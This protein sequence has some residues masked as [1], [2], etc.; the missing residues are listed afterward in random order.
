MSVEVTEVGWLDRIKQSLVGF[1]V[2]PI[3]ILAAFPTIFLNE[4]CAVNEYKSI[5]EVRAN[6]V[7]VPVDKVDKANDNKLVYTTGEAVTKDVLEDPRFGVA[8]TAVRLERNVEM[9]Q[10][11]ERSS[12]KTE[13]QV[14]GKQKKTTTY[15]YDETWSSSA[16]DSSGFND[17]KYRGVNPSMKYKGDSFSATNVSL[18]AFKLSEELIQQMHGDD[19][20]EIPKDI[21]AKLPKPDQKQAT[22]ANG[23]I[24]IAAGGGSPSSPAVGDLRISFSQAKAGPVSVIGQQTGSTFQA[25]QT[26]VGSPKLLLSRG[27]VTHEAML[28]AAESAVATLTWIMRFVG[29]LM[30]LIGFNLLFKPLAVLGDVVPLIGSI[31]GGAT[32]FVALI[33]SAVL[34][35]F[36]VAIAWVIVRPLVGIP[37][38]L[39][40]IGGIVLLI[41]RRKKPAEQAPAPAAGG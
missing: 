26:T 35:F 12:T 10:I 21:I 32:F 9:Y 5:G 22:L 24:Y 3:L 2:G 4:R 13:K 8:V 1:L 14:G 31:I 34:A 36:T 37:L 19:K 11:E 33:L 27:K 25:F 38:L 18:G 15:T 30:F 40:A 29:F 23:H 17:E 39:L 16:I 6:L 28:A 41:M 7:T 20:V